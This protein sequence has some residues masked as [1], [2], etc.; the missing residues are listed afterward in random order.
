M[1]AS[2]AYGTSTTLTW[3][4]TNATSCSASGAWWGIKPASGSQSTGN[5]T[6]NRTYRLWCT[7]PGGSASAA[8][9]VTIA[10]TPTLSFSVAPD[11]SRGIGYFTLTWSSTDVTSCAA[12]GAWSGSKL[13]SGS[14]GTGP[15]SGPTTYTLA[16]NGAAGT[17]TRT[18]TA[19]LPAPTISLDAA[20]G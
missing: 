12:T 1:P 16:C 8:V 11:E 10:A 9:T 5:L 15:I 4:T 7:G 6:R 20:P 17:V 2:V 3:S 18:V 14:E 13:P 19:E